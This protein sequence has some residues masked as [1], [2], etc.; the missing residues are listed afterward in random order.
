MIKPFKLER[1][2]AKHE[3]TATYLMSSSDAEPLTM[4]ELLAFAD[5]EHRDM[6]DNLWL[7]YTE[8]KGHPQLLKSIAS[9]Y[10]NITSENVLGVVPE[11]G[12]F[13]SM[14]SLLQASDHIVVVSPAYQSLYQ[15]AEERGCDISYWQP[16]FETLTFEIE[17]LASLVRDDTKMIVINF[18][19]NPTGAML[20]LEQMQAIVEVAKA[21]DCILFSD[22]M[23]RWSE[24][25]ESQRLPSACEIY[26]KAITLCGLSKTFA[27]PGLRVGWLATQNEAIMQTLSTFKDYTTICGSAPS[28]ILALIALNAKDQLIARTLDIVNT[29]LM[30]LDQFFAQYSGVV[31]WNRPHVGMITF[32]ELTHNTSIDTFA[33][34]LVEQ[35]GVMIVP[36]SQFDIEGN[37]FRLGYGRRNLPQALEHFESFLTRLT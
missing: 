10:D 32:V 26:D 28:E 35:E 5:D 9:L 18:P 24:Q 17:T 37:F 6:W 25:D 1:Y 27:L 19:H 7:G 15:I 21:H 12:I 11:E 33:E 14:S 13:I 36:A 22:E 29:N 4:P 31:R 20:T 34:Q 16:N 30:V 23:Y 8:S 3:F 2:F